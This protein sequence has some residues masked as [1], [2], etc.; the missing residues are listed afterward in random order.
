MQ[1]GPCRSQL[2]ARV[3]FVDPG[4]PSAPR[5]REDQRK[6]KSE[7]FHKKKV[8]A[9]RARQAA[10]KSVKIS[11]EDRGAL[12]PRA[13]SGARRGRQGRGPYAVLD[14][15]RGLELRAGCCGTLEVRLVGRE[16]GPPGL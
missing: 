9:K 2:G 16:L 1:V 15:G 4:R 7:A 8:A 3:R 14:L 12:A 13:A 11:A 10:M 6:V 5:R